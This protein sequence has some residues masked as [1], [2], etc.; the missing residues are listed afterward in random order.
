MVF[1]KEFFENVDFQK[2]QQQQQQQQ[3]MTKKQ[4]K[5]KTH[6]NLPCRQRVNI[7]YFYGTLTIV[8]IV[9]IHFLFLASF[10]SELYKL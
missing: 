9:I 4:N 10:H 2:Q 6:P 3:P 5:K 1:M 7:L 8:V